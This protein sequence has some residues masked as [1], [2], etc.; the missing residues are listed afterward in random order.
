MPK[1]KF[2][3]TLLELMI[4]ITIIALL[5]AAT[6]VAINPAKRVGDSQNARRWSDVTAVLNAVLTY[7]VDNNGNFPTSLVNGTYYEIG[8]TSSG[9]GFCTSQATTDTI[10]LNADIAGGGYIGSLPIDPTLGQDGSATDYWIYR[11]NT[12]NL[13]VGACTTYNSS[14]VKVS[15]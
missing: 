13:T 6:F 8:T 7:V 11:S 4:V 5:A 14:V 10:N 12:G 3:F 2:G 9:E 15:R 1:K